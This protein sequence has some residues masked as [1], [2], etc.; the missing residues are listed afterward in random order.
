MRGAAARQGRTEGAGDDLFA[1]VGAFLRDGVDAGDA[2]LARD[3]RRDAW[4]AALGWLTVRG[5]W[6]DVRRGRAA[7]VSRVSAAASRAA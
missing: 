3:Q 7:F 1:R 4:T 6:W 5:T 2:M